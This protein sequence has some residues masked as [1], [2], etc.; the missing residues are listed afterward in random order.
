M[1]PKMQVLKLFH[2]LVNECAVVD[3]ARGI[4]AD[5]SSQIEAM[6]E[7][8]KT[9]SIEELRDIYRATVRSLEDIKTGA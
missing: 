2:Q 6:N 9:A 8:V 7:R 4:Q 1:T 5:Y 3:S